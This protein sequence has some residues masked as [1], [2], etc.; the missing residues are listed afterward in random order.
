MRSLGRRLLAALV[1]GALATMLAVAPAAACSLEGWS[2]RD[3]ARTA[4]LIV[5]ATV[6]RS[7]ADG[8]G[9]RVHRVVKGRVSGTTIVVGSAPDPHPNTSCS[10]RVNVEFGDHVVIAFVEPSTA[11]GIAS[12]VWWIEPDGSIERTSLVVGGP[13]TLTSL[14]STLQAAV[15][16]TSTDVVVAQDPVSFRPGLAVALILAAITGY[17]VADRRLRRRESLAGR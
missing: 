9:L 4:E 1:V 6:T 3:A 5:D 7:T 2:L 17:V 13:S 15:P 8:I 11:L 10:G 12:A 16:D 14:L